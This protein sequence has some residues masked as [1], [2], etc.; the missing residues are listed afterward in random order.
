MGAEVE[1]D[2]LG[3]CNDPNCDESATEIGIVT[4]GEKPL[5]EAAFCQEHAAEHWGGADE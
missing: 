4:V 1:S 2:I 5:G 3:T